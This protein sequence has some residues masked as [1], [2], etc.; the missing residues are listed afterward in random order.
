MN[1]E[2]MDTGVLGD[3]P[4]PTTEVLKEMHKSKYILH[5]RG[6]KLTKVPVEK[7]LLP[8][9]PKVNPQGVQATLAPDGTVYVTLATIICKSTDGGRIWT[10]HPRG[11]GMD[12]FA[13]ILSD[14]TFIGINGQGVRD[15]P[16]EVVTSTDEGRNWL[17]ISEIVLHSK[18]NERYFYGLFRLPN[19][20]LICGI[21]PRERLVYE[22]NKHVSGTSTLLTRR[23]TDRGMTWQGPSY[24]TEWGSEGGIASTPSGKLLAVVRYQR[25]L[26][27]SDPPWLA[28]RSSDR[29][30]KNVFLADS[31]DEGRSWQNFRQLT[32]VYGQTRGYPAALSDGTVVV[33]HDTRYGPGGPGGR[34]MISY[35]EGETWEDEVYYL[36]Y[37][38]FTGSYNASVV[39]EDDLILSIVGTSDAGNSWE[40]VIDNTDMTAIRWRPVKKA[41]PVGRFS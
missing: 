26:L 5:A 13:Q 18:Y 15:D 12:G 11:E 41:S 4:M 33:I 7:N 37:T 31:F 28:E 17:K 30:Y 14:G 10:S 40:A 23:S 9:D 27:D 1:I 19:D 29:G 3:T 32:T 34:A 24:L 2:P 20:T 35:D 39:L 8:H 6:G 38:V 16:V 36:D 25:H 21:A 22:G